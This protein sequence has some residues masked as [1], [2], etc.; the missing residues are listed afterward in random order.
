[1]DGVTEYQQQFVIHD[2]GDDRIDCGWV[3]NICYTPVDETPCPDHAPVH[4]PG[5]ELVPCTASPRHPFMWLHACEDLG[6]GGPECAFCELTA[7]QQ[8][9]AGCEHARHPAWGRWWITHRLLSHAYVLGIITGH[10]AIY[11]SACDGCLTSVRWR[12]QRPYVLGWPRWKWV[13]LRRG[14]WP[15]AEYAPDACARCHP[16][17]DPR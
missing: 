15:G 5:L 2:T 1:M 9:H 7:A 8:A 17:G 13:C 16:G 3:C 14:H 12:G 4:V 6:Y 10:G 11:G